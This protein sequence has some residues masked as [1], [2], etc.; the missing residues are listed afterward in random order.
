MTV[1]LDAQQLDQLWDARVHGQPLPFSVVDSED[2]RLLD[3]LSEVDRP[4][5]NP[6]FAQA[7]DRAFAAG[8]PVQ[9]SPTQ[10]TRLSRPAPRPVPSSARQ[11]FRPQSRRMIPAYAL[12]AVALLL[13]LST[14]VVAFLRVQGPVERSI[15]AARLWVADGP[16]TSAGVDETSLFSHEWTT[17]ELMEFSFD[18]W[19][20]VETVRGTVG[21]GM[22]SRSNVTT[23]S[24][25]AMSNPGIS[26]IEV[27]TGTLTARLAEAAF[28]ADRSRGNTLARVAA[29][30]DVTLEAGESLVYTLG[31]LSGFWNPNDF[32]A[33][34]VAAGL[35]TRPDYPIGFTDTVSSDVRG[36]I[37]YDRDTFAGAE[38]IA[39]TIDRVSIGPGET[40]GYTIDPRSLRVADVTGDGLDQQMWVDGVPSGKT[41]HLLATWYS[42]H[43]DGPGYYTLTNTGSLPVDVYLFQVQPAR[44]DAETLAPAATAETLFSK[45]LTPE[46]MT[47][48]ESENWKWISFSQGVLQPGDQAI[49]AE[50][51]PTASDISLEPSGLGA[52]TVTS[53][54]LV[55]NAA[56]GAVIERG[57]TGAIE[58]IDRRADVSLEA[59]DTLIAPSN[60]LPAIW[61]KSSAPAS[62]MAG[63]VYIKRN[64]SPLNELD[65]DFTRS[66]ITVHPS[67]FANGAAITMS[68]QRV[69]IPPGATYAYSVSPCHVAR[70]DC[71][72]R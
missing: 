42:L 13:I 1:R 71:E 39:L 58:P 50:G 18:R 57:A 46:E 43:Q 31:A 23:Y 38:A 29:G 35:Y 8:V 48:Y 49:I 54:T 32:E 15:P 44:I 70:N 4:A 17:D 6:T 28:V 69:T 37:S 45:T 47:L 21:P 5:P 67:D 24:I 34:Y 59:G 60:T 7:L 66:G 25:D 68:L 16:P 26:I 11:T 36:G 55:A 53:G 40:Y 12:A 14:V 3:L 19:G 51:S 63:G 2:L 62:Y 56:S 64:I 33:S 65:F 41:R 27:E 52:I 20:W 10:P 72:W 9:V 22:H 30:T 61:N